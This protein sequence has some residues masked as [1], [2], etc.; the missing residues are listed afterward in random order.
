MTKTEF[1]TSLRT[2]NGV[3]VRPNTAALSV[4]DARHR[5]A[6]VQTLDV[7]LPEEEEIFEGVEIQEATPMTWLLVLR[8]S[9]A[10]VRLELENSFSTAT[11][12]LY[13][14]RDRH[15][16]MAAR[17]DGNHALVEAAIE[18][19]PDGVETARLSPTRV[20]RLVRAL[21]AAIERAGDR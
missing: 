16:A 1:L 21:T 11:V 6:V 19:L 7:M 20:V 4:R 2:D 3:E 8:R 18:G 10:I 17:Y 12:T 15:L 14:L 9:L 5:A 13:G